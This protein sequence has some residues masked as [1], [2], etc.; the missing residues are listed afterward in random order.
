MTAEE[1]LATQRL[2]F[3]QLAEVLGNHSEACRRK[4]AHGGQLYGPM[5][6]FQTHCSYGVNDLPSV[7]KSLPMATRKEV[8]NR[9]L[10]LS[11]AHPSCECVC[12]NHALSMT[13]KNPIGTTNTWER[14]PLKP[15][16]Q[17]SEMSKRLPSERCQ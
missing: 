11:L 2:S 13:T 16:T 5:R 4:G 6:R 3:L 17:I 9:I 8:V 14:A 7:P 10:Q 1:R 12:W 15:L